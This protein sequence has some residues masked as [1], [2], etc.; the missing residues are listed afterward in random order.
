[1]KLNEIDDE[2]EFIYI[3]VK[4]FGFYIPV[5]YFPCVLLTVHYVINVLIRSRIS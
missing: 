2:S 3:F 4:I 1:M 5:N